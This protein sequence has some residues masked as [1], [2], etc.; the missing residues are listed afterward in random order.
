M[1]FT[2][3]VIILGFIF[4]SIFMNGQEK[5]TFGFQGGVNY[6]SLRFEDDRIFDHDSEIGYLFGISTNLYL[7]KKISLDV[8]LNY[9]RKKVS[10][11]VPELFINS[12][13]FGGDFRNFDI[14]E[15]ITLPIMVRYQ[16]G[17]ENSFYVKGGPFLGY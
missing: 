12:V 10:V 14:Y 1:K 15:F 17:N 6:S 13:S 5:L 2:K 9:E 4:A 7:G 16:I 11:Y 3:L 8:E